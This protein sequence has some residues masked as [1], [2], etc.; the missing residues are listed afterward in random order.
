MNFSLHLKTYIKINSKWNTDL[1]MKYT[2]FRKI[3]ENLQYLGLGRG[4]R[5]DTK[6]MTHK[7][8][9]NGR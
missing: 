1:N 6:S 7:R 2:A 8:K 4:L 5:L 3:G 9:K